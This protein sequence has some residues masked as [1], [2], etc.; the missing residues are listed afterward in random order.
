MS[1]SAAGF[2]VVLPL[3]VSGESEKYPQKFSELGAEFI[4]KH[5][6]SDE[7]FIVLAK[8][9]LL[10]YLSGTP[11]PTQIPLVNS[12]FPQPSS[13]I[14]AMMLPAASFSPICFPRL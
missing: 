7:E 10:T 11:S 6:S 2:K 12:V 4:G 14:K 13:P 3:T 9:G 5:C 1:D 8:V